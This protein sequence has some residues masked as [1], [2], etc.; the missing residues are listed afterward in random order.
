[1]KLPV[2]VSVLRKLVQVTAFVFLVFGGLFG[3]YYYLADKLSGALPALSC[4]YDYQSSDYC[5]LITFQHQLAHRVGPGLTGDIDLMSGLMPFA[6][7]F[8]TFVLLFVVLNKA[9]C[10]W[11]CPLGT[12]QELLNM[13][14]RKLGLRQTEGLSRNTVQRLRPVKWLLLLLL[15]FG[16]PLLTGLGWLDH[17]LRDPYCKICPS[18]ILTTLATGN[19]GELTLDQ[20]SPVTLVLSLAA[21]FLFGLM[22]ALALTLRQPFCRIC[23]MLALHAVFRKIGLL[24]LVKQATPRCDRCGLCARACPM[25]IG[26][27]HTEMEKRDVTFDDCTLCG[28][29]VEFCPDRE[30][31]QL[32]YLGLPLFSSSPEYFKRRKRA[33]LHWDRNT[34]L[35][36]PDGPA[37]GR[38]GAK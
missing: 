9:F 1:M 23:P 14:G 20:A 6:V 27:I 34:L 28:R 29:C 5:T 18:R 33:Q 35:H 24:R 11:I 4:A 3:S 26:E 19:G 15:V 7:T 22:I 31:L 21:D 17:D 37:A 36:R 13:L 32:R 8:G 30:V 12:F 38:A 10:G 16:F 25:D 2:N